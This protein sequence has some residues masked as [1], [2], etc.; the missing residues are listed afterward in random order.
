MGEK[1]SYRLLQTSRACVIWTLTCVVAQYNVVMLYGNTQLQQ[2]LFQFCSG[3]CVMFAGYITKRLVS[4]FFFFLILLYRRLYQHSPFVKPKHILIVIAFRK[5]LVML[6]LQCQTA[7]CTPY[8]VVYTITVP[9]VYTRA[10][11]DM[12][13][14][15]PNFSSLPTY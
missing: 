12:N 4:F 14:S 7:L 1:T 2:P 11:L 13:I 15:G 10:L 5:A 8:C 3:F 6:L 9:T